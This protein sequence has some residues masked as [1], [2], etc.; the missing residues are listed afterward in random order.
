M[1]ARSDQMECSPLYRRNARQRILR[2][3]RLSEPKGR[4][5][6][7]GC[8]SSMWGSGPFIKAWSHLTTYMTLPGGDLD[9]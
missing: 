9:G 8:Q 3:G 1:N 4:K 7:S 2:P 5:V 6:R